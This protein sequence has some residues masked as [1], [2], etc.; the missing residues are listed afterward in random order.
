ML[1]D[2]AAIDKVFD[3]EVPAGLSADVRVGTLVRVR[4]GRRRVG[5]WAVADVE[6]GERRALRPVA[7]VTGWGPEP[8]TIDLAAWA[9]WRWAG[10]TATCLRTA[11]ADFAVSELPPPATS[12][13]APPPSGWLSALVGEALGRP[14]GLLRLPPAC[15]LT[16]VVAQVAQRGP[17]LVVLPTGQRASILAGRL[18]RAGAGVA[19]LPGEWPQARSGAG[20]VIGT[21]GAAWGPCPG[22]AAVVVIDGHDEALVHHPPPTWDATTV[23]A[24]RAARAGVPCL[25]TSPCPTL[26]LVGAAAPVHPGADQE[27][28]GWAT[29]E[30]IDRRG[31]DP[32]LGLYSETLGRR[33]SRA[34]AAVCVL[35]RTGRARLLACGP[36]G[37]LARC[38]HCGAALSEAGDAAASGAL[39]C[40]R[41]GEGR[42]RVCAEC[43]STR[44]RQ[45]RVGVSR[46]REE[47]EALTRRPVGEV[48]SA[49]VDLPDAPILVGTEAVL[50]RV[51]RCDVVAFLDFDQHLL[52]PRYRANEEA[53]ALLAGASRLVGG[54][55]GRVL[56]QT[57]LPD[58]EV[59]RAAASGEPGRVNEVERG[60]RRALGLPPFMTLAAISGE[61]AASYAARVA[62]AAALELRGPDEGRWLLSAPDP[63]TLA[64][65]LAAVPR[66]AGKLSIEV[67]PRRI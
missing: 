67:D 48:T 42:P 40:G 56:V 43:G 2:I 3:Y 8:E 16:P 47:L 39:R 7:K 30:V 11:S 41:C 27:R 50:N 57:R 64:D 20:V 19:L 62:A 5:G 18:R 33:L 22:L 36:C 15:D 6:C 38:E 34:A 9:A 49:T 4:L 1:P 37:S 26:D 13:P 12:P 52:A 58:H 63:K 54:R 14:F 21:R 25:V 32:R 23:A 44:L 61:A 24:E 59:L 35:N 66:P 65:A 51:R 53:L 31:D 55:S 46:A 45:L 17:T 29:L 60:T 28:S 10:R